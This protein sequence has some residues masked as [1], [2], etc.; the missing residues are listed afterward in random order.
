[1][2]ATH[3]PTPRRRELEGLRVNEVRPPRTLTRRHLPRLD[4]ETLGRAA[5]A[6]AALRSKVKR[7]GPSRPRIV[8][9][10]HG[11][12]RHLLFCYPSYADGDDVY[13]DAFVDLFRQLP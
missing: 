3:R 10:A 7:P 8:S 11:A 13:R 6:H 4:T 1:M 5:V 9:S 2:L 12:L